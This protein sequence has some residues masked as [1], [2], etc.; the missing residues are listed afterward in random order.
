VWLGLPILAQ[1]RAIG[2]ILATRH[3]GNFSPD[4]VTLAMTLA[5]QA[6]I[7]LE[8]A[9][10]YQAILQFNQHLEQV[11]HQRTEEL[12]HAYQRLEQLDKAKLDFIT[13]TAHELR[14][15]LTLLK[16][17]TQILLDMLNHHPEV[18]PLLQGILVGEERLLEIVNRMLDM[19][20]LDTAVLNLHFQPTKLALVIERCRKEFASALQERHQQ[21][22]VVGIESLPLIMADK[23]LVSKA[24]H[25]LIVN[26]IK[27]T[28]DGG[29]I[30]IS[31]RLV[32]ETDQPIVEVV[33]QDTGIGIDLPHQDLVFEKFYQITSSAIHSSGRTSFK[34]GGP[35]LGLSIARGIVRAHGGRIWVES[36]G[37]DEQTFPGSQF[38]VCL[39][40]NQPQ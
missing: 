25:H 11:V 30:T 3:Q 1:E 6:G 9:S 15:P 33:V 13:V 36:P 22:G 16:G 26:A 31:G 34:G 5:G 27:Y 38:H 37:H 7:A 35:G 2:M 14:T 20:K 19:T 10:L 18:L 4:E 17:Y 8:N 12:N 40:I 29:T 24:F 32:Q 28:P 39:P 23:D 21:F